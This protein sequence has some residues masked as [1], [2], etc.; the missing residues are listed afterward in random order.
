MTESEWEV[1]KTQ[2]EIPMSVWYE[3]YRERGG[4]I[5]DFEAFEQIFTEMLFNQ[6]ILFTSNGGS[7]KITLA[8]ATHCIHDYYGKKFG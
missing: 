7:K 8:S 5:D 2:R 6:P 1:L 4:L 3:Y